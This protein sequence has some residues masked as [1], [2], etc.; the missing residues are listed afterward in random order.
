VIEVYAGSERNCETDEEEID[1]TLIRVSETLAAIS[2][3]QLHEERQEDEDG[4]II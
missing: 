1:I 3:W 4:E 2:K